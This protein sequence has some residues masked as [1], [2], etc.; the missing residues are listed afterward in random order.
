MGISQF[1]KI[2]K[3]TQILKLPSWY[4]MSRLH[5]LLPISHSGEL[6]IAW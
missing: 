4:E 5:G 1:F 3:E 6:S 2:Q